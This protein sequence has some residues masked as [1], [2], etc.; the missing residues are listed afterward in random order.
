[1]NVLLTGALGNIGLQTLLAL[2]QA[3]HTVKAFDLP[4]PNNKKVDQR[5]RLYAKN[6][7][8]LIWGDIL[9]ESLLKKS[10]A[11][12]DAVIHLAAVLPPV[13]DLNPEL[14]YTVNVQGTKKLIQV[15]EEYAPKARFIFT[16]TV[17]VN[18][19]QS[20]WQDNESPVLRTSTDAFN[21]VDTY[22][23]HK[24]ECEKYL[25]DS[26]LHWVIMRIGV[27]FGSEKATKID[28][29]ECRMQF[30][31]SPNARLEYVHP[32][33]VAIALTN[34]V[35]VTDIAGKTLLIGGGEHCQTTFGQMI[36]KLF[37]GMGISITHDVYGNDNYFT[38][39][40]DTT[41]SQRLLNFQSR[42]LDDMEKEVKARMRVMRYLLWPFK[43]M[44]LPIFKR[45][46]RE[47]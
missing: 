12:I 32:G 13:S 11:G 17:G 41:E 1:M 46:I 15:M 28:L 47:R 22:S 30:K 4:S 38:E 24:V 3:G 10:V 8:E 21:P 23:K 35:T 40:L 6:H 5:N 42:T 39:W 18:G 45:L 43:P 20:P 16:S 25:R 36:Q 31:V 19:Y 14:A 2:L 7:L 26:N 33:D 27:C 44:V 29:A 37:N 9:D 34:A